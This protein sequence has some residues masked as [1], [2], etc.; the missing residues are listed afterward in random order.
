MTDMDRM[1]RV[2][3]ATVDGL[4]LV[5]EMTDDRAEADALFRR[6]QAEDTSPVN[7]VGRAIV[8]TMCEMVH[9]EWVVISRR[10]VSP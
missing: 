2:E 1:Y 9:G 8:L 3:A 4:G 6:L 7:D 10:M 5:R